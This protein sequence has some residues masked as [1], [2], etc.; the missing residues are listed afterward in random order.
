MWFCFKL[1]SN[2]NTAVSVALLEIGAIYE[3]RVIRH[4]RWEEQEVRLS[5]NSKLTRFTTEPRRQQSAGPVAYIS[6]HGMIVYVCMHTHVDVVFVFFFCL[7]TQNRVYIKRIYTELNEMKSNKNQS[8]G[9]CEHTETII[10]YPRAGDI[11]QRQ[12]YYVTSYE[13]GLPRK[14]CAKYIHIA[15]L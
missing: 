11:R 8:H 14:N 13:F 4:L 9:I 1:H 10:Y 7:H 15:N 6:T 2:V 12:R 5:N 3:K